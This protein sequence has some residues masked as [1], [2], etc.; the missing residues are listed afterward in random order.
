MIKTIEFRGK[1]KWKPMV[2]NQGKFDRDLIEKINSII[3]TN[4]SKCKKLVDDSK[5]KIVVEFDSDKRFEARYTD[6]KEIIYLAL[7]VYYLEDSGITIFNHKER[8]L[9][10][11]I[12]HFIDNKINFSANKEFIKAMQNE[13]LN[14][15]NSNADKLFQFVYLMAFTFDEDLGFGTRHWASMI[16]TCND[17]YISSLPI[18]KRIP[19]VLWHRKSIKENLPIKSSMPI[20]AKEYLFDLIIARKAIEKYKRNP[21]CL[22]KI[23]VADKEQKK[24]IK[25][26]IEELGLNRIKSTD[27]MLE[28]IVPKSYKFLID[29][30]KK[31][32]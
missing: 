10:E 18:F 13:R 19:S 14:D 28:E 11:E 9:L 5:L 16:D 26:I 4:Y 30:D 15:T 25:P 8:I 22:E 24:H 12:T 2:M 1:G 7:W 23:Y 32:K 27:E 31:V 29:F 3:S 17:S 6:E 20:L 21:K